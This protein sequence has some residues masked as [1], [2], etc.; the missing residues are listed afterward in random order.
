MWPFNTGDCLIEVTSWTSL[1]V[2]SNTSVIEVFLSYIL[3]WLSRVIIRNAWK[4]YKLNT[5]FFK[6]SWFGNFLLFYVQYLV[7]IYWYL[8]NSSATSSRKLICFVSILYWTDLLQVLH[9]NKDRKLERLRK[10]VQK[11]PNQLYL[12]NIVFSLYIFH[13]FLIITLDNQKRM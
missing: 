1:T 6:Y 4:M 7:S 5:I 13:A 3:F 10:L 12:K 8:T 9:M 11:F 2:F